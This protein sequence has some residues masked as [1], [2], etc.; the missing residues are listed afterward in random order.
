MNHDRSATR[1]GWV[2][3][4]ECRERQRVADAMQKAW[5]EDRVALTI[6]FGQA[7]AKR[8]ALIDELRTTIAGLRA[9]AM[10]HLCS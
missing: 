6:L 3:C 8:E 10:G 5:E 7:L 4:L 9:D 2:P 1:I